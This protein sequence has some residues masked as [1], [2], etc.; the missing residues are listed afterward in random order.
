M[1]VANNGFRD[2]EALDPKKI[3]EEAGHEVVISALSSGKAEGVEGAV[4]D[5]QVVVD[6]INVDDYDAVAFIGGADMVSKV[7]NPSHT[8]L[9]KKF[10]EAG[11]LTTAICV[12]P[13]ILANAGIIE[14]KNVTS[15][16]GVE[17]DL[18]D[19]GGNF[20]GGP[21]VRDELLITA[22]GPS[23]AAEFGETILKALA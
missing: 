20:I 8:G 17:D 22:T 1:V 2:E 13:A 4:L 18:K 14:G 21:V 7:N 23:A 12:A 9:A 19:A 6:D 3:L 10:F 11:K 15:W 5:V 16:A